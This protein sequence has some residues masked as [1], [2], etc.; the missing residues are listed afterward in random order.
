[1]ESRRFEL[2]NKT[3]EYCEVCRRETG[4]TVCAVCLNCARR[5]I[6]DRRRA[7]PRSE[8]DVYMS[9][10][11]GQPRYFELEDERRTANR[12]HREAAAR[13]EDTAVSRTYDGKEMARRSGGADLQQLPGAGG[14]TGNVQ[15]DAGSVR[16]VEG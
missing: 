11:F 5:I 14:T 1:M 4:T 8:G 13:Q 9:R 15:G 3:R 7:F 12:L 6:T 2:D 10:E 16:G